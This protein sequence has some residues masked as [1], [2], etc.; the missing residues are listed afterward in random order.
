MDQTPYFGL[1]DKVVFVAG[2]AGDI[3]RTIVKS[4]AEQQSRV[5]IADLDVESAEKHAEQLTSARVAA[6][7]LDVISESSIRKAVDH[8]VQRFGPIDVL[9]NAAGVLCRKSFFETTRQD[10]KESF[11]VNVMGMF[12][13][14]REVAARMKERRRGTIINIS[15]MNAKLAVENRCLYG[16]TKAAVNMLTQSMAVELSP[17][18]ITVNAVAPG[19]VDSKM[20]R[21]RLNTPELLRQYTEAIPLKQMTL[22]EDVAYSV[23]FLASP[24]ARNISGEILLVD[25]ALTARM[26]LPKPK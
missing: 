21:V 13:V 7:S 5:V 25:G 14:S 17:M 26:P 11:S 3:G 15:S 24:F 10:F 12:L 23:L 9:V 8:A 2:G 18:G 20:A 16:A 22:P 1:E 6:C 4:F 19:I